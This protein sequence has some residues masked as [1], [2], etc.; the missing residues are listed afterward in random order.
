MVD[1]EKPTIEITATKNILGQGKVDIS[2]TVHDWSQLE[3]LHE[4]GVFLPCIEGFQTI[5]IHLSLQ[6]Q[7]VESEEECCKS[8]DKKFLNRFFGKLFEQLRVVSD[9][10]T[11]HHQ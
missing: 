10:G 4:D 7:K 9:K 2:L 11:E 6:D 1:I 3:K 5:N 8:H